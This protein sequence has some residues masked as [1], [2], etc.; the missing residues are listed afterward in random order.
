MALTILSIWAGS[1]AIGV[2]GAAAALSNRWARALGLNVA[3]GIFS[4]A[5]FERLQGALAVALFRAGDIYVW[6]TL[7]GLVVMWLIL[8][9]G[10]TIAMWRHRSET[11]A[12]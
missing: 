12:T 10:S 3:A 11:A 7:L 9:I 5:I 1:I 4:I 8:G 6:L 2:A